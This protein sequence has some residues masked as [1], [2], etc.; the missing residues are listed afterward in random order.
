MRRSLL[1][2]PFLLVLTIVSVYVRLS[3]YRYLPPAV[4]HALDAFQSPGEVFWWLTLGHAFQGYPN[5][6]TG[7]AVLVVSNTLAWSVA[8][9]S[10]AWLAGFVL[11]GRAAR[12]GKP[13]GRE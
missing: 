2:T 3:G 4:G 1:L 11:R 12:T 9:A 8:T 10:S 6:W 7:Y 5:T 13:A